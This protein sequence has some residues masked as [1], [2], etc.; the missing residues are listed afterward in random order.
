MELS[1][2]QKTL[3]SF[4]TNW[5]S[6]NE[7]QLPSRRDMDVRENRLHFSHVVVFDVLSD[8]L[9]FKYRLVGTGVREN[10]YGDYTGKTLRNM[11]GK[12]PGSVIWGML[13]NTRETK[14][15]QF[16]QVP[17]VGPNK[18]FMRSTLLFLPLATDHQTVDKIFLVSNFIIG[19]NRNQALNVSL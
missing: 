16:E 13:Y 8:P 17:Y 19:E 10:T 4:W 12:G 9:D 6:Q 14:H 11:E 7:G 2:G 5:Q 15:P 1:E 3:R 18:S